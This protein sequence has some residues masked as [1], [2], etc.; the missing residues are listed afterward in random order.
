MSIRIPA[1][2]NW[3][4]KQRARLSGEI[5]RLEE[6]YLGVVAQHKK[7]LTCL[8]EDLRAIDRA[9][10]LH[11]IKVN[12][13]IVPSITTQPARSSLKYGDFTKLI[14]N[15]IASNKDGVSVREVAKYL[16]TIH[17][18]K[19]GKE[20]TLKEFQRRVRYRMKNLCA[21]GKLIWAHKAGDTRT[22][23]YLIAKS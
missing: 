22:R 8:K 15:Y 14:L 11:E 7:K 20:T 19:V 6:E 23:Y 1:S 16:T 10:S 4:V 12:P 5:K 13:E 2:L 18:F 9:F 3:L 21:S 17:D